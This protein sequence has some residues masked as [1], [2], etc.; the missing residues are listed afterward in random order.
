MGL[1]SKTRILAMEIWKTIV[2]FDNY[3]ISNLGN[4][5]HKKTME[6]CIKGFL[7]IIFLTF[8]ISCSTLC[9]NVVEKPYFYRDGMNNDVR[10]GTTRVCNP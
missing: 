10:V 5:R 7:S 3:E 6:K 1:R 4:I 8:L 9:P 2:G